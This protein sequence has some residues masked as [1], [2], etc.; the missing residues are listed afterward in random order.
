M[1]RC[2]MVVE[3]IQ[4]QNSIFTDY[5]LWTPGKNEIQRVGTSRVS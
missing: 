5:D 2:V 1:T 4:Q 3:Q